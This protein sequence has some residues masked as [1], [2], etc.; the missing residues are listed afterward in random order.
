MQK[1]KPLLFDVRGVERQRRTGYELSFPDGFTISRVKI[2]FSR[3]ENAKIKSRFHFRF[4]EIAQ[5]IGKGNYT[6]L[7]SL[8]KCAAQKR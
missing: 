7:D 4:P 2:A 8:L 3:G 1:I 6:G 5:R